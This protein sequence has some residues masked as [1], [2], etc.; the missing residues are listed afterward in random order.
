MTD[1]AHT[2]AHVPFLSIGPLVDRESGRTLVAATG[3]ADTFFTRLAGLQFRR[4]LPPGTGLLIV[5]CSSI[6]TACMRFAIDV[7]FLDED[8]RIVG[9]Q[10]NVRPW[11]LAGERAAAMTLELP[12]GATAA[13]DTGAK[14]FRRGVSL[15][16]PNAPPRRS[17]EPF[18]PA[19]R[20]GRPQ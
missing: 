13:D 17:L 12:A 3:V 19:E 7:V 18:R 8:A 15:M 11:R 6:H 20:A 14:P 4:S 2:P 1:T 10:P 9:L 5:P 16:L